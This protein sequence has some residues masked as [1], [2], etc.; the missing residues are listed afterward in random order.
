MLVPA[1][2]VMNWKTFSILLSMLY[3]S[4][5]AGGALAQTQIGADIDGEAAG[6]QSGLVSMSTNG[7]RLAI[8]APYNDDNGTDSG[9]VRVYT[10]S[11]SAWVQLGADI[12]GEASYDN[13]G[14]SVSMSAD[15]NRLA[16]GANGSDDNGS[17]SGHVRVYAWSGAA[18]VQMGVD[19]D[20]EA[21]GDQSGLSVSMSADGNRVTIG[22]FRNDGNGTN[23]GH[24]RVYAWSGVA[25]VQMG[26]DIDGEAAGDQSGYSV[27]MSAAGNRVAINAFWNDDNGTDSGHV[28]VY[29]WSGAAWVQLGADIDGEAAGDQSGLVS[30]SANGNRVAIGAPYSDGNGTD[31]GHVRVYAWSGAAWVQVGADIDGEA[32]YDRSGSS[33]SMSADGNRVAIGAFGNDGNGADSGH[34]RVYGDVA[35]TS[36]PAI[37]IWA[38]WLLVG[39]L[40]VTGMVLI[41]RN[42]QT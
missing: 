42:Y 30:M 11:G 14:Y 28:R 23:S 38:I 27:A 37:S 9:H 6:D 7:N 31:S 8:G 21:A 35:A 24:A 13:S 10:W 1:G 19:I 25:W 18:W 33:V 2:G 34:V 3:L 26:V 15:G 4:C 22:A 39:M 40:I 16:I 12:D 5:M 29:A 17:I 36:I 41:H 32:S 20:G